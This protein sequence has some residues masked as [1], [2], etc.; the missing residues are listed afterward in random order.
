LARALCGLGADVV[1]HTRREDRS[2]PRRVSMCP[3]VT[4]DHV[5]AGPPTPIDKDK[6]FGHMGEFA[7]RLADS[8]SSDPP[9]VAHA[10]FWMSGFA[11]VEATRT[12]P[13]PVAL[14]YH[15]LGREKQQ[16][17]GAS[18]HSPACRRAV[19]AQLA[20]QVDH[21]I[22]TTLHEAREIRRMGASEIAV[23][24]CGVD[25]QHF[26]TDGSMFHR[27][28][29]PR[30]VCVSR[31]VP[32]KGISDVIR[33]V[34]ALDDV[35]LVVAGGPHA[36]TLDRDPYAAELNALA[37]SMGMG[38]RFVLLGAVERS[39]VPALIRSADVVCCAPW[40]EPFGMVAL[41]AMAC[42]VPVVATRVGGLAETVLNGVTGLTVAPRDSDALRDAISTILADPALRWRMARASRRRSMGYAWPWVAASTLE[43]YRS[44]IAR[45][46]SSSLGARPSRLD[47][48]SGTNARTMD[49]SA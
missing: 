28:G 35:E 34:A 27:R 38:D 49:V 23:I 43:V 7:D 45:S 4:V 2:L 31:L 13:V 39:C 30:V 3:G 46:G 19:E 1:V 9:D 12:V 8:W 25:L 33:A 5:D 24:P 14:T 26:T 48:V 18:D 36:S 16:H 20:R 47:A 10:H 22:A 6:L 32:R 11:A 40:Y 29:R 41:E 44:M 17:Q 15:A 21:V 42:A 37:E